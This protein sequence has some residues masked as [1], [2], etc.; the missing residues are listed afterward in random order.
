MRAWAAFLGVLAVSL[1]GCSAPEPPPPPPSDDEIRALQHE[2]DLEWWRA[3]FG[4]EEPPDV[5]VLGARS[6]EEQGAL[7]TTCMLQYDVE[8]L[9]ASGTSWTFDS[10]NIVESAE[11]QRVLWICTV[12][13]PVADAQMAILSREQLDWFYDFLVNRHEPCM[14]SLGYELLGIPDKERFMADSLGYPAWFP[15]PDRV[16]PAIGTDEQSRIDRICPL[17][18]MVDHLR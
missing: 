5:E 15:W 18:E 10:E 7:V 3:M 17:P 6:W 11:F 14:A 13:Y 9:E 2:Q 12:A 16:I 4:D 1:A 8:G